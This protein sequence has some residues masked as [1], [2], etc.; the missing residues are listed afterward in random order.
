MVDSKVYLCKKAPCLNPVRKGNPS[1]VDTSLSH[2][3]K[4]K[5][6]DNSTCTRRPSGAVAQHKARLKSDKK[7]SKG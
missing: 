4:Q 5:I 1:G 2:G 3:A 7:C 6:A